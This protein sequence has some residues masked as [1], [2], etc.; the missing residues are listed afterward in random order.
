VDDKDDRPPRRERR[1]I[2]STTLPSPLPDAISAA[3]ELASRSRGRAA[4]VRVALLLKSASNPTSPLGRIIRG[5]RG[6]KVR[7][8][9]YLSLIW[10]SAAPPHDSAYPSRA[11]ATLLGLPDPAGLGARRIN[12]A[13]RWLEANNFV[14]VEL[15][16]GHPNRV[17]L[18]DEVG[19]GDSYSVPGERTRALKEA[20]RARVGDPEFDRHR[21]IQLPAEFWTSGRFSVLSTPAVAMYMI[22]LSEKGANPDS[23][24]LWLSPRVAAERYG[25]SSD[26]RAAGF[27]ELRRA[28]MVEVRR[29][30]VSSGIF[31]VTRYRNVYKLLTDGTPSAGEALPAPTARTSRTTRTR[32]GAAS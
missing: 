12:E 28:G 25:L 22:L 30:H 17:T 3:G 19:E 2:Q 23:T 9:L 31:D 21:Y 26:T 4:Q 29:R 1:E 8:K 24:E 5:G 15:R 20:G 16:P 7:L 32:K 18:L 10:L 13:V 11:W 14:T 27:D 6:G